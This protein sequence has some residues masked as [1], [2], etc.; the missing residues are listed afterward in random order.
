[1]GN[2][3]WKEESK[4][5]DHAAEYYDKFRPSYPKEIIDSIIKESNINEHSQLLEI[6]AGSGK[7]TELF[8]K[9]G[10]KIHCIEPGENLAR[11]GEKRFKDTGRVSYDIKRFE[12]WEGE[13]ESFDLIYS[14]QAFHWVPQPEGFESCS[15]LLKE[16]GK[17]ALLWNVYISNDTKLD[18]ELMELSDFYGGLF[19]LYS[20]E[21]AEALMNNRGEKIRESNLFSN[22]KMIKSYWEKVYSLDEYIGFIKTSNGYLRLNVTD[23]I[24]V[25]EDVKR[26]IMNHGGTVVRPYITS[27]Y[28][29]DNK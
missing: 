6:G 24:K 21:E 5:F 4:R 2:I 1:M 16:S 20:K 13:K 10:L 3:D 28:L 14:A 9:R 11:I 8:V 22:I 12:E 26:I 15:R 19:A 7:A 27:L 18:S 25:E 17:L 23:R 29:A